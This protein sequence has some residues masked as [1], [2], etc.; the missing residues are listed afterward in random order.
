[1]SA[2]VNPIMVMLALGS[3]KSKDFFFF[4]KNQPLWYYKFHPNL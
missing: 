4:D 3:V 2:D 1:M